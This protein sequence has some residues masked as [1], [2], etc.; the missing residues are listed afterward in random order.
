MKKTHVMQ[1]IT[2]SLILSSCGDDDSEETGEV[3]DTFFLAASDLAKP[4]N[5]EQVEEF[6][7]ASQLSQI[8]SFYN[9][10]P[11]DTSDDSAACFDKSFEAVRAVASDTQLKLGASLD[12]SNCLSEI[13]GANS[14]ITL[15]AVAFTYKFFMEIDC[16]TGGLADFNGKSLGEMATAKFS[17][18]EVSGRI[19]SQTNSSVDFSTSAAGVE[20]RSVQNTITSAYR[21]SD[22]P[23]KCKV[24]VAGDLETNVDCVQINVTRATTSNTNNGETTETHKD[25]WLKIVWGSDAV[26]GSNETDIWRQSGTAQ[27]EFNNWTGTLT[28]SNKDVAPTYNLSNGTAT[29]EGSLTATAGLQLQQLQLE[30]NSNTVRSISERMNTLLRSVF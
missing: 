1:A 20:I 26:S 13:V 24:T 16:P 17:C 30:K 9:N 29:A 28:Y 3:V 18:S 2:M 22:S 8:S 11:E 12:L 4:T 15:N 21:G 19:D 27:V 25:E 10:Q 6:E 5:I 7:L 14:N 23:G